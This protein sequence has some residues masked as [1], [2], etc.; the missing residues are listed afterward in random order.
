MITLSM[1]DD[2]F[3]YGMITLSMGDNWGDNFKYGWMITLSMDDNFKY[4]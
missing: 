4:G 1:D 3:K 2:N